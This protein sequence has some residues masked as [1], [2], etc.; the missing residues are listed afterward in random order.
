M[1]QT[2]LLRLARTQRRPLAATVGL[3]TLNGLALIAQAALLARLLDQVFLGRRSLAAVAPALAALLALALVRAA[4]VWAGDMAA[5]DVSAGVRAPLRARLID[6]MLARGPLALASERT[7]ELA[8]TIVG[9][10][11]SLDAYYSQYLPQAVVAALVPAAI[12]LAVLPVDAL[13]GILLLVTAP[14]IPIFGALVGSLSSESS[15][16]QWSALSGFSAHFL[17]VLQGL[18]TLKLFGRSRRQADI[19]A[20]LGEAYR[21]AT[22]KTLRVAFLSALT[23]ELVATLSVAVIAVEIGLRLL[24]GQISFS[25][26]LFVLLLAPEFYLPLR[27]LG[28]KFHAAMSGVTASERIFA[29]LGDDPAPQPE[30]QEQPPAPSLPATEPERRGAPALVFADVRFTYPG[31]DHPALNG[32]TFDVPVGARVAIVGPSGAGKS[33]LV[34]LLLRFAKADAGALLVDGEPLAALD[35]RAWRRRVAWISQQPYLFAASVAENIRMARPEASDDDVRRA[36]LAAQ[37]DEF[38][39]A[40][41]QG[42]DTQIG[43]QG[44]RLSGGQA[45]RLALARAF[46]RDAPLL[47]LDE[48]TAQLDPQVEA[49]ITE[50]VSTLARGRTTLV[51]AH[52]LSTVVAVDAIVVMDHGRV[53]DV[54]AHDALSHRCP[55]Y[56]R[57]IAAALEEV[58]A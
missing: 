20:R 38:I 54:G 16:E 21:R 55:L 14:L 42:Y 26:A 41:P 57:L 6:R 35:A 30:P 11:E 5:Q 49:Q 29:A 19:I 45:Q 3:A 13:S 32:V 50:A 24:Y 1:R 4:L 25:R 46:L 31:A 27:A 7:G 15:R 22:M 51:I 43:E 52:R 12:L 28:A 53:V 10:V 56:Q 9:G 40:L 36:A 44:A 8:N 58:V 47:L 34:S 23:L 39:R 33:T 37:A 2:A 48:P 17:D 18:T